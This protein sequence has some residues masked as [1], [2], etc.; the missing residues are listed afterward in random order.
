MLFW[1]QSLEEAWRPTL[2]EFSTADR[3]CRNNAA[4]RAYRV[5]TTY[6]QIQLLHKMNRAESS[7]QVKIICSNPKK[8]QLH[9]PLITGILAVLLPTL[10]SYG[11]GTYFATTPQS[12]SCTGS[13][14]FLP[15]IPWEAIFCSCTCTKLYLSL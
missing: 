2:S 15:A 4:T 12:S 13:K 14:A 1:Y 10:Y 3:L 5:K 9:I 6:S 7:P 8:L 11:T